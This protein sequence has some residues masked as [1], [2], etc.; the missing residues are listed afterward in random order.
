MKQTLTQL[1][2]HNK[3]TTKETKK[4]HNRNNINKLDIKPVI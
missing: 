4:Q 3:N 1:T 2:N